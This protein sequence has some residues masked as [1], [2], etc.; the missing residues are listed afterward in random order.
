MAQVV[1]RTRR[2]GSDVAPAPGDFVPCLGPALRSEEERGS[3]A[4][5]CPE[6]RARGEEPDVL[7]IELAVV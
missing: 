1:P 3:R 2:A 5:C 7:P 6:Q 4:E